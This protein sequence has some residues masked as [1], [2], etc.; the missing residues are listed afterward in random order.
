MLVNRIQRPDNQLTDTHPNR[1]NDQHLLPT[2]PIEEHD[3]WNCGE[4]VDHTNHTSSQQIHR[5]ALETNSLENLR[6]IVDDSIDTCKLLNDLEKTSNYETAVEVAD[7]EKFLVLFDGEC[8]AGGDAGKF[9]FDIF[10]VEN[11]GCFNLEEFELNAGVVWGDA[12]EAEQSGVGFF[13]A[14]WITLVS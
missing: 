5:V 6:G 3:S 9:G 4:E 1:T 11:A 10:L 8:E 13:F 7:E 2:P 14:T 12:T